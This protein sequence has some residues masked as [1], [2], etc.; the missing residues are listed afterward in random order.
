VKLPEVLSR[1]TQRGCLRLFVTANKTVITSDEMQ[2]TRTEEVVV[3]DEEAGKSHKPC[4]VSR[5]QGRESN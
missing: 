3:F 2:V 4:H 1:L 5:F